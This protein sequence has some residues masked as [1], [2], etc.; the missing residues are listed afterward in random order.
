MASELQFDTDLADEYIANNLG[1][2]YEEMNM[3][4]APVC[5]PKLDS[6]LPWAAL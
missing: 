6:S 1:L 2:I 5:P 4:V 3:F